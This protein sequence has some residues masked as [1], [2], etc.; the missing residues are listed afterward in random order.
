MK[1]TRFAMHNIVSVIGWIGLVLLFAATF[2]VLGVGSPDTA[3]P[4]SQPLSAPVALAE[5]ASAT[6]EARAKVVPLR[7]A[8]LRFPSRGIVPESSVA[9]VLIQEGDAV[10]QG[11]PLL[12]LDARDLQLG[13]EE[14]EAALNRAR[15]VYEKLRADADV[16]RLQTE[17]QTANARTDASVAQQRAEADAAD[18]RAQANTSAVL[19]RPQ[20]AAAQAAAAETTQRTADVLAE[21]AQSNQED[22]SA[23]LDATNQ[24]NT[25]SLADSTL[26]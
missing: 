12:R 16:T 22:L 3:N 4:A 5:E 7:S 11:T 6:L 17:I 1:K 18:R 2:R 15:T 26:R 20:A 13:V 21:S 9:E 10:T 23:L 24:A 19:G 8:E 25:A 14:A